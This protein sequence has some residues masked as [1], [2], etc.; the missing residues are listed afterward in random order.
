M[1][2]VIHTFT[3]INPKWCVGSFSTYPITELEVSSYLGEVERLA[4]FK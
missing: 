1:V 4:V 2:T 3:S